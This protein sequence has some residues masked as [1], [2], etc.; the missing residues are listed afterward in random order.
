MNKY[1]RVI[2]EDMITMIRRKTL[3]NKAFYENLTYLNIILYI[4]MQYYVVL[5][6]MHTLQNI[7]NIFLSSNPHF[8][9]GCSF[10]LEDSKLPIVRNIDF[11]V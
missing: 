5:Q 9:L 6:F 2:I 10:D 8:F 3:G 7:T 4:L 1:H 11:F